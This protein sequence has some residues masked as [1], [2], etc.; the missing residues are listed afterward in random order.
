MN[1]DTTMEYKKLLEKQIT[2][3]EIKLNIAMRNGQY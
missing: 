1:Q 2:E 3:L